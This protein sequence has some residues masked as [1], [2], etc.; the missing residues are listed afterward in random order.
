MLGRGEVVDEVH[1]IEGPE[2][3]FPVRDRSQS[4]GS[5]L[6]LDQSPVLCF[7]AV[8]LLAD[9]RDKIAAL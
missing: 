1:P 4:D 3:L 6:G 7:C 8:V 2:D 9:N 5:S